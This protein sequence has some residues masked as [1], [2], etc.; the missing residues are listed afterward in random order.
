MTTQAT[1]KDTTTVKTMTIRS[2]E[3]TTTKQQQQDTTV[4]TMTT[5]QQNPKKCKEI[6]FFKVH[7]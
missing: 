4:K 3:S 7:F 1:N 5:K 2:T 6:F